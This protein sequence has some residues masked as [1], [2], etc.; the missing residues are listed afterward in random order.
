MGIS[1]N[2]TGLRP[3]VCTST[4]RPTNP[5]TGQII[6]ETNTGY[7]RVWDGAAWDYFSP[8]QDTAPGEWTTWSP[9]YGASGG[10]TIT[11][12]TTNTARYCIVNKLVSLQ[13][14][15]T[16]TNAGT[17]TG[18]LSFT[19]PVTAKNTRQI[20][21]FREIAALG[22][23]GFIDNTSTTSALMIFYA[24]A[25]TVVTNYQLAGNFTYEA[26]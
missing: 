4:T 1:S 5:Y 25:N 11:T 15:A 2:A 16:V 21:V 13:I 14:N 10:G 23:G 7:L 18:F 9:T 6:Y 24:A 19:L 8:K 26:A 12:M 17:G 3:G 22:H 20:G